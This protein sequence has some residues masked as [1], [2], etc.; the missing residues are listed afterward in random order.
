MTTLFKYSEIYISY[1]QVIFGDLMKINSHVLF[2]IIIIG[3]ISAGIVGA[4]IM[5]SDST[6]KTETF[7]GIKISVP[8]DSDFIKTG[9][10]V[11]KDNNYGIT[12][13]TFKNNNS[14]IDF[15]KNTKK[16]K[17][18]PVE[19]QPPQSVAFKKGD[20]INILVTNGKEGIS[21][22]SNDGELTSKIANSIIFSNNQ[23]SEKSTGFGIA[24]PH[25]NVNQDFNL[26]ML[27]IADVDTNIFNLNI[28]EENAFIVVDTYNYELEEP[29]GTEDVY[30]ESD[31]D[32]YISNISDSNDLNNIL[33]ESDEN[34]DN[35]QTN[36]IDESNNN[37][38]IDN[39]IIEIDNSTTNNDEPN[40]DLSST[41]T[42]NSDNQVS[43]M[44][45]DECK[46][47]AEKELQENTGLFGGLD[48][49]IDEND[50]GEI[51]DCYVFYVL[52]EFNT[53]V[54]EI[55]VNA[56]TGEVQSQFVP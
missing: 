36:S 10:G 38:D 35:E 44:S 11:Y 7:D 9:D 17:I 19:N 20:T 55:T 22:G 47:L 14:M 42:G 40:D 32:D 46:N 37:F 4:T 16:S 1:T 6:M 41:D 28:F 24:K 21:V 29:F 8:A 30:D 23:K 45:F 54:A 33:T 48:L 53:K 25:M 18:I 27:L 43:E 26:I 31:S 49:T 12:I 39:G 50:H 15:L 13:N 52:D 34:N 3:V 5:T 56:L 2:L 51:P